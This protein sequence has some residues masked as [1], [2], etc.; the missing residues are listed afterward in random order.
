M[1]TINSITIY[2]QLT[3]KIF[4]VSSILK[5]YA[6]IIALKDDKDNKLVEI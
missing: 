2:H 5:V 4:L 6:L 1:N 3:K